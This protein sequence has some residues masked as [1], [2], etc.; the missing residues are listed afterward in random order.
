[1]SADYNPEG[2]ECSNDCEC[3]EWVE[4]M[5][6]DHLPGTLT[7]WMDDPSAPAPDLSDVSDTLRQIQDVIE[8][9]REAESY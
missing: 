2:P 8:A 3:W 6:T 9:K 7:A 5:L 1:M 4:W